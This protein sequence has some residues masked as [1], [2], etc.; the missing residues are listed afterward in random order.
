M[1][2][3]NQV[4]TARR[5][6]A[7]R[8]LPAT[9]YKRPCHCTTTSRR[10][11]S[12]DMPCQCCTLASLVSSVDNCPCSPVLSVAAEHCSVNVN[13]LQRTTRH[14][15]KRSGETVQMS[16]AGGR[17]HLPLVCACC[18][19]NVLSVPPTM[20]LKSVVPSC[21]FQ[22]RAVEYGLLYI[23]TVCTRVYRKIYYTIYTNRNTYQSH[24]IPIAIP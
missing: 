1:L 24:I 15:C 11:R 19:I 17:S 5:S 22:Y 4:S 10:A 20:A 9:L 12:H 21:A 6:C 8:L 16:L 3:H 14:D 13:C 2:V 23:R 18:A 7:A